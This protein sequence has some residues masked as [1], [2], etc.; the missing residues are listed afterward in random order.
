MFIVKVSQYYND[1]TLDISEEEGNEYHNV[2]EFSSLR[3]VSEY[4]I[5]SY[6]EWIYDD[7][8]IDDE[9]DFIFYEENLRKELD[10]NEKN[11]DV[12]IYSVGHIG[13]SYTSIRVTI[14]E[15]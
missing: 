14:K 10:K 4:L 6:Y 9:E 7:D 11:R 12:L 1:I 2:Y 13:Q 8:E 15:T 5:D 3:S